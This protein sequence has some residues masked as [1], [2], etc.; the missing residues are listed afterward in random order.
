VPGLV[1][2]CFTCER[3]AGVEPGVGYTC[4]AFG[5]QSIP[6]EILASRVDHHKPFPGDG[7]LQ[8]QA[9]DGEGASDM[10]PF[11]LD[12]FVESQIRRARAGSPEG[13]QF[14]GKAGGAAS[15][16]SAGVGH[17]GGKIVHKSSEWTGRSPQEASELAKQS[18][19]QRPG[20]FV[21]KGAAA[22]KRRAGEFSREDYETLKAG[23]EERKGLGSKIAGAGKNLP[24][25]LRTHLKEE[26]HNAVHA[27]GA[28]KAVLTPGKKPSPEQMK[29]LRNFGLRL[30]LS[31]ASMAATGEPTGAIGT[32]AVEFGRELV[33]HVALEHLA[34]LASG[35][36]RMIIGK[37]QDDDELSPEDYELLQGFIEALAEAVVNYPLVEEEPEKKD[38]ARPGGAGRAI[39]R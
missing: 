19:L 30:L 20:S 24:Q 39:G 36:G 9:R 5:E 35:A 7:G 21:E 12:D 10:E 38:R 28:L 25:A 17:R 15:P 18:W 4:Q 37:D 22:A 3:F 8:Y 32:L 34:K 27:A 6:V 26:K 31:S 14:V 23:S 33:Q 2:I 11:S 1:P 29:G 13:G 16:P